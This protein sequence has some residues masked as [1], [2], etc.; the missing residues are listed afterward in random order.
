M[1]RRTVSSG[2][3][4]GIALAL[5]VVTIGLVITV[6][7]PVFGWVVGPIIMICG[8]FIGGKRQK[9]LICT[10]KTCR[11]TIDAS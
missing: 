5:I 4:A 3:C 6:L 10:A 8:L 9:K 2:N 1:I 11:T 7:I